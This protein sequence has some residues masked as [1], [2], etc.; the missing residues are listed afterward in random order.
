MV[1]LPSKYKTDWLDI[2]PSFLNNTRNIN[3]IHSR[4]E[5]IEHVVTRI[6]QIQDFLQQRILIEN[7]SSYL[8]YT[9]S[10]C[11]EWEFITEIVNRADCLLLCDV[12]NIYV[13]AINHE[14]DPWEYI[15]Y[16]PAK[17]FPLLQRI[18]GDEEF[19]HLCQHYIQDYPSLLRSVRGYG[20]HMEMFLQTNAHYQQHDYLHELAKV[21]WNFREVFDAADGES[22]SAVAPS[23]LAPEDWSSMRLT[24]HPSVRLLT[25][26]WNVMAVKAAIDNGETIP[27]FERH[28]EPMHWLIWRKELK[29]HY[30]SLTADAAHALMVFIEG[31]S[32]ADLCEALCNFIADEAAPQRAVELLQQ[33]FYDGLITEVQL[34][35]L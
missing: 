18:L 2:Y 4:E 30:Y 25:V 20:Q 15:D 26:N 24:L 11:P 5:T 28:T 34:V 21:E 7:V 16:L 27:D 31:K 32:F 12:N 19:H 9:H 29:T 10:T 3:P 33:W 6:R 8:T 17:H 13:S 1:G 14:F 22:I 23:H 35:L